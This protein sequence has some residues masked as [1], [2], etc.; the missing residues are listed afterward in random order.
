LRTWPGIIK[1]LMED[2]DF[3]LQLKKNIPRTSDLDALLKDVN[4]P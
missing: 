2:E 3:G 4:D 1:E